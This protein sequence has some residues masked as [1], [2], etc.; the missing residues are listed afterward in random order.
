LAFFKVSSSFIST[1]ERCAAA[2]SVQFEAAVDG[3]DGSQNGPQVM[4]PSTAL[5]KRQ[6]ARVKV[7]ANLARAVAEH[8]HHSVMGG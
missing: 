1:C 3:S 7:G 5:C 2:D 8:G 6:V 4:L